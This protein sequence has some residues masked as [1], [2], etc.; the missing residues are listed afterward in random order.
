MRTIVVV[1][2]LNVDV[3]LRA[4]HLPRPGETVRAEGLE[5]GSG[6]KGAN[7]AIA[8]ARL[9]GQVRMIGC[10]GDDV[11][12]R[13][14]LDALAR[15]GVDATW[16]RP[17]TGQHTGTA[18]ITVDAATGENAIAVAGGANRAIAPEHVREAE[19]AFLSAAVLLVQLEAPLAVVETALD[20]AHAQGLTT[21]LDPAPAADLPDALLRKA[22]ILTPNETEAER[23]TGRSVIDVDSAEQAGAR[24]HERSGGQIL[25]T[26]ADQGC[27]LVGTDGAR[28][29]PAPRV[30]AIDS[31]GAG[32]AFNGGLAVALARGEPLERAL[33]TALR[34]GAAATLRPGAAAAM[35]T[36]E[37]L[38]RLPAAD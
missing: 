24:L 8:A 7:Q 30:E 34:A 19:E 35:P 32:D 11:F 22:D 6:G 20:L 3:S 10:V 23:L 27:V 25:I 21:V 33:E 1:G 12:A 37:D 28:H 2:S 13:I 31:T 26:L 38:D 5:I 4:E 29:F 36:P 17:L 16:V 14:P 15:A 9:G 18:T